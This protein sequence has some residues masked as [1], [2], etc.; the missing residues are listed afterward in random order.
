MIKV[1]NYFLSFKKRI[2]RK[3]QQEIGIIIRILEAQKNSFG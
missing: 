2:F 1:L 3:P